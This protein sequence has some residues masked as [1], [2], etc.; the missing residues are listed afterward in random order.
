MSKTF[1]LQL[2]HHCLVLLM[3]IRRYRVVS[4]AAT[5][6]VIATWHAATRNSLSLHDRNVGSSPG[7]RLSFGYCRRRGPTSSAVDQS[8]QNVLAIITEQ[9]RYITGA[10]GA[11]LALREADA[12]ICC[13]SSGLTAPPV[14]SRLQAT[15]SLSGECLR[16]GQLLRC[17]RIDTD[18]RVDVESCRQ[19]G[20][21]SLIVMPL[22]R[23]K[24]IA[25]LFQL[26]SM[27]PQAFEDRDTTVLQKLGSMAEVALNGRIPWRHFAPET[28]DAPRHATCARSV[29]RYPAGMPVLVS[30]LQSGV[31]EELYGRTCDLSEKGAGVYLAGEVPAGTS[32]ALE[33]SLPFASQPYRLRAITRHQNSL[34][35]GFEFVEVPKTGTKTPGEPASRDVKTPFFMLPKIF[36][37]QQ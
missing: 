20:I 35:H 6:N 27:Q 33:F 8:L 4:A 7:E 24:A 28:D 25:G 12:I 31:P 13:A 36:A 17:N 16:T 30:A 1:R 18:E 21:E 22:F 10:T 37:G 3:L 15:S 26:L 32:V 19:L 2:R 34:R 29:R 23:D 14:N 9:A 5:G 11:A